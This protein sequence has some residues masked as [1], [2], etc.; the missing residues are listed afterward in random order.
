[1]FLDSRHPSRY[2]PLA[3]KSFDRFFALQIQ[4]VLQFFNGVI[5][6]IS[7]RDALQPFLLAGGAQR[8]GVTLPQV[9]PTFTA[10]KLHYI[11]WLSATFITFC[12]GSNGSQL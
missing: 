12:R 10:F 1:M 6:T 9:C 8:P 4:Y 2:D 3:P 11:N 5:T 7:I